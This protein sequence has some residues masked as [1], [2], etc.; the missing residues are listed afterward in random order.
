MQF[1]LAYKHPVQETPIRH[2]D[3]LVMIGSCFAENIGDK[4]SAAKFNCLVNP[5][6]ILFNPMSIAHALNTYVNK[7]AINETDIILNNGLY[8]SLNHHGC[9]SNTDKSALIDAINDSASEAH[10]QLK[11]ASHL[12]ITFGTSNVY[13]YTK[14]NEVVANCHKLPQQLFTKEQLQPQTII[15]AYQQLITTLRSF[16]PKLNII[17]TVSPVKYLRDG[18]IENNLSKA[19]LIY[20]I[21]ELIKTDPNC[22]YFPAY[23]LVNDDLRDHRFYK[24]DMAHPNQQ[25]ID[26]V[27]EQFADSYFNN[28]TK[29]LIGKINDI[30][31]A[32]SHRTL[33]KAT[34]AHE[35]FK[36]TY[37]QKC[38]E[39]EKQ[40]PFLN[41][42]AEKNVFA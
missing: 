8:S 16:N 23:E 12:L 38:T 14:T 9:F 32:A 18:L 24:E 34:E 29:E 21:H 19:V 31:R 17:F 27:W 10:H 41:F 6:G 25:A 40:F 20:S 1:H 7:T 22:H 13:R 35:Q 4:L 5:N 26:Y 28:T 2:E 3:K 36:Q 37:L 33:H 11:T 42:N 30:T 15:D 39:L